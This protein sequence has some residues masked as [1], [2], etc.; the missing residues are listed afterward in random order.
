MLSREIFKHVFYKRRT[1]HLQTVRRK[2][3]NKYKERPKSFSGLNLII[4]FTLNWHVCRS[5]QMMWALMLFFVW[6]K[7]RHLILC[8]IRSRPSKIN[9]NCSQT[10]ACKRRFEKFRHYFKCLH[11]HIVWR[12]PFRRGYTRYYQP[13]KRFP[14]STLIK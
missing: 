10:Q 3:Q 11:F 12:I 7:F 4:P 13:R 8:V 1:R 6:S 2:P 14:V 9:K 5:W